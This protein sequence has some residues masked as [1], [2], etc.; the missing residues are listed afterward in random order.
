MKSD[1]IDDQREGEKETGPLVVRLFQARARETPD[2][3]AIVSGPDSITYGELERRSNGLAR[4]LVRRGIGPD[5]LVGVYAE[6]SI[7]WIVAL[8]AVWKAGGAYLPLDP[9]H[10]PDRI[11]LMFANSRP[12]VVLVQDHLASRV[13]AAAE[14]IISLERA[15]TDFHDESADAP[16]GIALP[17][18]LAYAIYTSGSTGAP[19]AVLVSHR[20][21]A[22]LLTWLRETF[23]LS[24]RDRCMQQARMGFDACLFEVL[25]CLCSGATLHILDDNTRS[26]GDQLHDWL[27]DERISVGFLPPVLG[28]PLFERDLSDLSLRVLFTGSD[29]AYRYP[30]SSLTA[31]YVNCYGPTEAAVVVTAGELAEAPDQ[32]DGLPP[33]GY[34]I[35]NTELHIVD[36]KLRSVPAG[37]VGE[38]YIGGVQLARGYLKD[39]ALTSARFV[40]DPFSGRPGARLY[41]TG[42]LARRRADGS[43]EF[44]G[45]ADDQVKLRGFRVEPAEVEAVLRQYPAVCEA[46][47]LVGDDTARG[48]T[49]TAYLLPRGDLTAPDL[50]RFMYARLPYYMVPSV[51]VVVD[52]WPTSGNGKLDRRRLAAIDGRRL[53]GGR[54]DGGRADGRH[55]GDGAPGAPNK[56]EQAI[57]ADIW[58]ELLGVNHVDPDD[59]FFDLGG[60]SLLGTQ[61]VSRIREALGV[62]LPLRTLFS[63]PT[64]ADCAQEI[65]SARSRQHDSAP[66]AIESVSRD[67]DLPL[68]FPQGRVWFMYKLFPRNRAYNFQTTFR[69]RGRLDV[70]A[71]EESLAELTQRHEVYRTTFAER[72]GT[73]YQT[74]HPVCPPCFDYIDLTA[75]AEDDRAAEMDRI[76]DEQVHVV[77]D[78]SRL[79]LVRWT[80]LALDTDDHLLVHV[81][82]HMV[83]D[84]WS[85]TLLI[86]ELLRLYQ[87]KVDGVP[88]DLPALGVQFADYVCWQ[89]QW[90]RNDEAAA[91]L[92]YWRRHLADCPP[93]VTIPADHRRPEVPSFRGSTVRTELDEALADALRR[94]A[95]KEGATL[96]VAMLA[97][98]ELLL[99]RYTG[100]DDIVVGSSIANRH[101]P[102]TERLVGMLVNNV[103]LRVDLSGDPTFQQLLERVKEAALGAYANQDTPFEHVVRTVAPDRTISHNPLFQVAFSFH[104]AP[105]PAMTLPGLSMSLHE[106]MSN[107]TAKFDLNVIAI[108]RA[109]Q[110]L[111]RSDT[112]DEGGVLVVYEYSTDL[113]E[114]A[115][116]ERFAEHYRR[117]AAEVVA[118]PGRP[119][120]RVPML[121][122]D[123]RRQ[124]LPGR[125]RDGDGDGGSDTLRTVPELIDTV[126]RSAPE[127][128]AIIC[129][130]ARL[131][132]RDLDARVNRLTRLI[133]RSGVGAEDRVA[134]FLPADEN[135]AVAMLAIIRA[136]AVCL[137]VPPDHPDRSIASMFVD[138]DP[139]LVLTTIELDGRLP[140]EQEATRILLDDAGAR[141]ELSRLP[142][143]RPSPSDLRAR[144]AAESAAWICC[145]AGTGDEVRDVVLSHRNLAALATS[146]H[147][148]LATKPDDVWYT[149]CDFGAIEILVALAGG[150]QVMMTGNRGVPDAVHLAET[151]ASRSVAVLWATPETW[152]EL[153]ELGCDVEGLTAI[154]AG[155]E[156]SAD[157]A[158]ILL[159][160][161]ARIH[162]TYGGPETSLVSLMRDMSPGDDVPVD[163]NARVICGEPIDGVHAVVL[164]RR[165]DLVPAGVP[166]ELYIGGPGVG[167]GYLGRAAATAERFVADRFSEVPG[168]RLYRTGERARRLRDGGV[169]LLDCL[170]NQNRRANGDGRPDPEAADAT[171]EPAFVA[172]RTPIEAQLV[173]MWAAL[174]GIERVG[175]YDNFFALGGHS[176]LAMVAM[177]QAQ[178]AYTADIPAAI[179]FDEPTVAALAA[180]IEE[181]VGEPGRPVAAERQEHPRA[182]HRSEEEA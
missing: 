130:D 147:R 140:V 134:V 144:S 105:M 67:R 62:S 111:G 150:A 14:Q 49:L 166:G 153:V 46:A 21:M 11:G 27:R 121:S 44:A 35:G 59:N 56:T 22:N 96:F 24:P 92:E 37:T 5:D 113:F 138:A 131:T 169:E 40:A 178:E 77:F 16:D 19:K 98:F 26:A 23:A 110:N 74:I 88:A 32:P 123:D 84:G 172:A 28:E 82:H 61:A 170:T 126:T 45:R 89:H 36:G 85:F 114:A 180:V 20:A 8:L 108:P 175:V 57:L 167:R 72:E 146:L 181:L 34:P 148:R 68:S 63:T 164:D 117:L 163:A 152:R 42:D 30:P 171:A 70:A 13:P 65:R 116:V 97:V 3:L 128:P 54:A 151:L 71:L 4:H 149:S 6:R 38:L 29:R 12:P 112:P 2:A 100:Q 176:M 135:L 156:L 107:G 162:G 7:S 137:P 51:Y 99:H 145:T 182:A 160:R 25:P 129:G 81:E 133:V 159:A 69:I 103:A 17:D 10:P 43:L 127:Q 101:R 73:P 177:N 87:A 47:V 168:A 91:Q 118:D 142:D 174:L 106:V 33:I 95:H 75:L 1:R 60:H 141:E 157:V 179:I 119:I 66:T 55:L 15:H 83:H 120:S 125:P 109:E 58:A 39:P 132:Y 155:G 18:N 86:E 143:T 139:A 9:V 122:E 94:L 158:R 102:E 41:R 64:L 165:G 52:E 76:V 161:G 104:D 53:D 154:S 115:T 78:P 80:L 124:L 31:S 136:G 79:P 90:V 50:R 93:I 48:R 173:T